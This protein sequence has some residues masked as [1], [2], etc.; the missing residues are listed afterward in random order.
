MHSKLITFF[1]L[2]VFFLS[3]FGRVISYAY[4]KVVAY[5]NTQSFVC[6]C[7]KLLYTIHQGANTDKQSSA[8]GVALPAVTQDALYFQHASLLVYHPAEPGHWPPSPASALHFSF[9]PSVF[10]PPITVA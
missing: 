4:C 10:H 2:G 6:D 1:A 3:Q 9:G 5:E 8:S 7:E